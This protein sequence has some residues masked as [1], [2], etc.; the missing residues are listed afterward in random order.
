MRYPWLMRAAFNLD[1]REWLEDNPERREA[2]ATWL[3]GYFNGVE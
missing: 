3:D 1:D 2:F